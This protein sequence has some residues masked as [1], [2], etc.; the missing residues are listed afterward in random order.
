M[1]TQTGKL[2]VDEVDEVSSNRLRHQQAKNMVLHRLFKLPKFLSLA[3]LIFLSGV[4]SP[5]E[6][7]P[8]QQKDI[9]T[10]CGRRYVSV[11]PFGIKESIVTLITPRYNRGSLTTSLATPATLFVTQQLQR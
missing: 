8:A 5:H 4:P 6:S 1:P 11:L 2:G 10:T 9:G 3:N 7:W